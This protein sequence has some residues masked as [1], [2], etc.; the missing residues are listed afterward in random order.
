MANPLLQIA[1]ALGAFRPNNPNTVHNP[2]PSAERQWLDSEIRWRR[3]VGPNWEAVKVLGQ[4]G[5]GIVGHWTYK[6]K[7]RD[8]RTMV[9]VAVKQASESNY[10]GLYA[11]AH[12]LG[13]FS[14]SNNPHILKMYRRLYTEAGG[15]GANTPVYNRG[16]IHRVFLE[17]CP[18]GDLFNLLEEKLGKYV[19]MLRD[20][21]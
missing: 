21:S 6:G 3:P 18:G 1:T 15:I 7:D 14:N 10:G 2:A 16:L 11:E 12:I 8:Q 4:G 19:L 5:Q 9:D 17:Y 13:M 20:C